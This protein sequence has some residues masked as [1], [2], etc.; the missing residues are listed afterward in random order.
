[1]PLHRFHHPSADTGQP[2][3]GEL[4]ERRV[5]VGAER[6]YVEAVDPVQRMG[7]LAGQVD[8]AVAG[9]DRGCV[10]VLPGEPGAR[11][12]VEDLLLGTVLVRRRGPGPVSNLDPGDADVDCAGTIAK[13]GPGGTQMAEVGDLLVGLV[14]V[15]DPL[16][17]LIEVRDPHR[18]GT[19]A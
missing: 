12:H 14:E 19:P 7:A 9:P 3:A 6:E 8:D 16:V 15:R 2:L 5:D 13:I 17:G 4:D 18:G 11:Q 1:L 10:A